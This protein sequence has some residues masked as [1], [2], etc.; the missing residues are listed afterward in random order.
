VGWGGVG[1]GGVGWGGVGWG[2]MRGEGE[3]VEKGEKMERGEERES[4]MDHLPGCR[5]G[6]SVQ[7]WRTPRFGHV[8]ICEREVRGL[9]IVS[10][11]ERIGFPPFKVVTRM[12]L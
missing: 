4:F 1:W 7:S 5:N 6:Q 2:E 8:S 9:L 3:R 12:Q 10:T 11:E